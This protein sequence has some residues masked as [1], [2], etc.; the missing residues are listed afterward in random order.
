MCGMSATQSTAGA[1]VD[2]DYTATGSIGNAFGWPDKRYYETKPIVIGAIVLN[3]FLFLCSFKYIYMKIKQFR[4]IDGVVQQQFIR[5]S[6]RITR[7]EITASDIVEFSIVLLVDSALSNTLTDMYARFVEPST[8]L[9][10]EVQLHTSTQQRADHF[11]VEAKFG[12]PN[13]I[14]GSAEFEFI[15]TPRHA[16]LLRIDAISVAALDDNTLDNSIQPVRCSSTRGIYDS[17]GVGLA[18]L[19]PFD[20]ACVFPRSCVG[21]CALHQCTLDGASFVAN[22]DNFIRQNR[23]QALVVTNKALV[24]DLGTALQFEARAVMIQLT[25]VSCA[26]IELSIEEYD[27]TASAYRVRLSST[28]WSLAR[29]T[30]RYF[31]LPSL[32]TTTSV[33]RFRVT[34]SA[35]NTVGSCSLAFKNV[36]FVA[37]IVSSWTRA[38]LA[39]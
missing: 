1:A 24:L 32:A 4:N 29:F 13:L 16:G 37:N 3:L 38:A 17:L 36:S 30:S 34:L 18:Q 11:R 12:Y 39:G 10:Q 35:R 6:R 14:N 26:V 23:S 20:E 8:G 28:R 2:D 21:A 31:A 22:C 33:N 19:R 9:W 25:N 7:R 15:Y 27:T 5:I